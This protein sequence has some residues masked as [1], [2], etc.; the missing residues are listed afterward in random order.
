MGEYMRTDGCGNTFKTVSFD[1]WAFVVRNQTHRPN[2]F[3]I[4]GRLMPIGEAVAKIDRICGGGGKMVIRI[5]DGLWEE[6]DTT[7]KEV[8][9]WYDRHQRLWRVWAENADGYQ[10]GDA[11]Y[12]YGKKEAIW[13]K[14]EWQMNRD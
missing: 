9:M 7:I 10:V 11:V 14:N 8:R 5:D 6:F 3:F 12:V 2:D 1:E 13:V 4:I